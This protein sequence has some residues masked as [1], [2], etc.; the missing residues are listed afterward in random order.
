[1]SS[2]EIYVTR[3]SAFVALLRRARKLL[4]VS[5]EAA[6][7]LHA[8]GAAIPLAVALASRLQLDT[9]GGLEL[10]PTTGSVVLADQLIPVDEDE[11]PYLQKRTNSTI[12]IEITHR[13]LP[14]TVE[15][16][17]RVS[18]SGTRLQG[19]L[20]R[21]FTKQDMKQRRRGRQTNR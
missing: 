15:Q 10:S 14:S 20:S 8:I 19:N 3:H 5:R 11:L 13:E 7:V 1:V 18:S 12:R 21:K 16:P 6:V 2:N 4:D 9:N 17:P